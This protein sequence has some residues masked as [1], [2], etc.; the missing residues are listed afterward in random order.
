MS[1][2]LAAVGVLLLAA[3]AWWWWQP[4]DLSTPW[5]FIPDD[6]LLVI[7]SDEVQ[8][9]PAAGDSYQVQLTD[10][11][12]TQQAAHTLRPLYEA[13]GD[14]ALVEGF[15]HKKDITYSLHRETA[16]SMGFLVYVPLFRDDN[17][18]LDSI[19]VLN[20]TEVRGLKRRFQGQTITDVTLE[21]T[22]QRFSFFSTSDFF[23]YSPSPLL[24]ENVARRLNG[25][26]PGAVHSPPAAPEGVHSQLYLQPAQVSALLRPAATDPLP[27]HLLPVGTA[28]NLSVNALRTAVLMQGTTPPASDYWATFAGQ[29]PLSAPR[30]DLVPVG[31]GSLIR[32][33]LSQPVAWGKRFA[34]FAGEELPEVEHQ[35][36]EWEELEAAY[37]SVYRF[38][39]QDA[40]LCHLNANQPGE[41]LLLLPLT[42]AKA[43]ADFLER[44]LINVLNNKELSAVQENAGGQVIS[45][46]PLH[47]WPEALFGEPF[48]G[49][50][51]ACYYTIVNRCLVV[52]SNTQVIRNYLF[53]L[54]RGQVWATAPDQRAFV[55][56]TAEKTSFAA[57][58]DATTS[59]NALLGKLQPAFREAAA[60]HHDDWLTLSR[61]AWQVSTDADGN[62]HRFTFARA[63]H[64]A[65]P[66]LSRRLMLV[67]SNAYP[68]GQPLLRPPFVYHNFSTGTTDF[69]T[70]GQ[71]LSLLGYAAGGRP[72]ERFRLDG[73]VVGPIQRINYLGRG[74]QQFLLPTRNRL[75]VLNPTPKG[76]QLFASGPLRGLPG[77][78]Y[79]VLDRLQDFSRFRM[80]DEYGTIYDVPK[81]TLTPTPIAR[82]AGLREVL[83]PLPTVSVTGVPHWVY[84]EAS[85][86]LR[87]VSVEGRT[88]PGFPMQTGDQLDGPAFVETDRQQSFIRLITRSGQYLKIGTDG[89]V[90]SREQFFL[91]DRF[92]RFRF[93]LEENRRDYLIVQQTGSNVTLF[94]RHRNNLL[95][96]SPVRSETALRYI[97]FGS[98]KILLVTDARGTMLYDLRGNKLLDRFVQ[99][100]FPVSLDYVDAYRKLILYATTAKGLETYTTKI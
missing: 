44:Q 47:E 82:V 9:P 89:V 22:Q 35:R 51:E 4:A 42:D 73:P 11:P 8:Q 20:N 25:L 57:L 63:S 77:Y 62:H 85:G 61:V 81:K 13:L 12:L 49:F 53:D 80:A 19:S 1:R 39:E 83:L 30:H 99:S 33:S 87:L 64:R 50:P 90:V 96:L 29:R 21:A 24:V 70:Q 18:F 95:T 46:L 56:K 66:A 38:M 55:Q 98:V 79:E 2:L 75:Y 91:P 17:A 69:I 100:I 78:R 3:L 27:L 67:S 52:G 71:N 94:D 16:N 68:F 58:F 54:Q 93:L 34:D 5:A 28:L 37:D 23:V 76:Y 36:E 97:D 15:L 92:S 48:R 7:R 74:G 31:T 14:S 41:A 10:W 32:L 65:D 86:T 59:W 88:A 60:P 40:L 45:Q 6:Y 84:A 72:R 43:S 26:R